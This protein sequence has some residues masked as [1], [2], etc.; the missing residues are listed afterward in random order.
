MDSIS[1]KL[2]DRKTLLKQS[3]DYE[4]LFKSL[5]AENRELRLKFNLSSS[6]VFNYKKLLQI[7]QDQKKITLE[8]FKTQELIIK[9]VK[10]KSRKDKFLFFGGGLAIG[11]TVF[12]L[13]AN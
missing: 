8:N 13:L 12:A 5:N 9:S 10:S 4:N 6:Q 1:F 3:F 2:I 7:E 11:V